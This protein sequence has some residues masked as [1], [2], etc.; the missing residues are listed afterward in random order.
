M[1]AWES[2]ALT[3]VALVG[4]ALVFGF[5]WILEGE[6]EEDP[7]LEAFR[8]WRKGEVDDAGVVARLLD[9]TP[10]E[11]DPEAPPPDPVA[12]VRESFEAGL[13]APE[14]TRWIPLADRVPGPEVTA[15]WKE[16]AGSPNLPVR[17]A[18][19]AALAGRDD[20]DVDEFLL[21]RLREGDEDTRLLVAPLL[22]R[23]GCRAA[24][25]EFRVLL[26]QDVSRSLRDVL[27]EAAERL[28]G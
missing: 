28:E 17:G 21:A 1:R 6:R 8:L 19:L 11:D 16:L 24:L 25:P 20:P 7:F 27:T 10:P 26:D 13:T 23:R 15:R 22:A 4:G 2:G 14:V 9:T 5:F 18:A 3:M 12:R